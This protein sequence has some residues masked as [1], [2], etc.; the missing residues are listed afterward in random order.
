M[1]VVQLRGF[2]VVAM[3]SAAQD[4][5]ANL[6]VIAEPNSDSNQASGLLFSALKL[7]SF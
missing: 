2:A 4:V 1:N 5:R 7:L 6:Q 3:D